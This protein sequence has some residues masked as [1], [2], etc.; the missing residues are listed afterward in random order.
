M[1]YSPS[2]LM[3]G[4]GVAGE[5]RR[6][7]EGEDEDGRFES[8]IKRFLGVNALDLQTKSKALVGLQREQRSTTRFSRPPRRLNRLRASSSD[9]RA[10]EAQIPV[11]SSR[12]T[13]SV[14]SND[15]GYGQP[16]LESQPCARGTRRPPI[17]NT[18]S[19]GHQQHFPTDAQRSLVESDSSDSAVSVTDTSCN[20]TKDPLTVDMTQELQTYC[21]NKTVCTMVEP[22][23]SQRDVNA[24]GMLGDTRGELS[25]SEKAKEINHS[26]ITKLESG[27]S[28]PDERAIRLMSKIAALKEEVARTRTEVKNATDDARRATTFF[29]PIH[30]AVLVDLARQKIIGLLQEQSWDDLRQRRFRTDALVCYIKQQ[31]E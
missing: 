31:L 18:P 12:D 25:E 16:V 24:V 27:I 10:E 3:K 15:R 2:E 7:G 13:Q 11:K 21:G 23:E 9:Q 4:G 5:I 29:L 20:L 17:S 14:L 8:Y 19:Q 22:A 1:S 26:M 28:P 6:Y 30:I